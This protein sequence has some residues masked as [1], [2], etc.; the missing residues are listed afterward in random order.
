MCSVY[1]SCSLPCWLV[2]ALFVYDVGVVVVVL[3]DVV[4]NVVA[5]VSVA[6]VV[7]GVGLFV[8]SD[9]H[10]DAME[11]MLNK[12]SMTRTCQDTLVFFLLGHGIVQST[13]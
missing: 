9:W 2:V 3:D 4:V 1:G 10:C 12:K 6:G 13:L 11:R 5:E 7:F 8:A